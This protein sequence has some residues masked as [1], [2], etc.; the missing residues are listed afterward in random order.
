M[1]GLSEVEAGSL[2]ELKG[3]V[4]LAG[5]IDDCARL[6]AATRLDER[7]PYCACARLLFGIEAFAKQEHFSGTTG[8][9]L[10]PEQTRRDNARFVR[11][12]QIARLQ[13]IVDVAEDAIF[14]LPF[15]R[16]ITSILQPS[17]VGW[18]VCAMSS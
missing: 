10:V 7:F 1:T 18:G 5:K 9:M 8:F 3:I 17:R 15:S 4:L 12:E 13:V 2:L 14:R 11:N 6:K 16:F